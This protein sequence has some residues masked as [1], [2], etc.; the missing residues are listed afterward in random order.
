MKTKTYKFPSKEFKKI[1]ME[2]LIFLIAVVCFCVFLFEEKV[3]TG[4]LLMIILVFGPSLW[5]FVDY[6]LENRNTTFIYDFKNITI[7]KNDKRKDY[8]YGDIEKS[9]YHLTHSKKGFY[10]GEELLF[11]DFG[12]WE[13]E[14]KNGDRYF[15]TNFI[16]DI[17][18]RKK[19]KNTKIKYR[20]FPYI[21]RKDTVFPLE[22]KSLYQKYEEK[23]NF[24][25]Q[26]I[27][28][29]PHLYKEEALRI[30]KLLLE[31]REKI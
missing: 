18:K 24:E 17:H 3:W 8:L 26:E 29:R 14:F 28:D 9:I 31:E 27:L 13:V 15:L 12:Y 6:Y 7:I 21:S 30:A 2:H 19:G 20:V 5:L 16:H 1:V 22:K 11:S 4:V 23:S 10:G 25:L